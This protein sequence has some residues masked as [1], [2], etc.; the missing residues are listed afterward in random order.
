M[1]NKPIE[2]KNFVIQLQGEGF[3]PLVNAAGRVASFWVVSKEPK[4][5]SIFAFATSLLDFLENQG[6][7]EDK[8]LDL[9]VFLREQDIDNRKVK[10]LEEYTFQYKSHQFI[11]D[12]NA[13]WWQKTLKSSLKE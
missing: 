6:D 5:R 10:D 1:I 12:D 7:S 4:I 9:A 13:G 3:K 11:P 2:Y 8:I